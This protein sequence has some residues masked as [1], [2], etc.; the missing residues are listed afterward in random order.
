[1]AANLTTLLARAFLA[2]VFLWA[3]VDKALSPAAA[4]AALAKA[5]IAATHLVHAIGVGVEIGAALMLLLGWKSRS[6]AAL[7]A[8][9]SL[10]IGLLLYFQ[11]GNPPVFGRFLSQLAI[12]GGLMLVCLHGAGRFSLDRR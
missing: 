6:A 4:K 8:G 5:G 3:G 9:W 7:L 11:P 10:L 2:A 1:V 12:A